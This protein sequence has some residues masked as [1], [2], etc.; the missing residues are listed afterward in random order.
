[1]WD[2]KILF[3]VKKIYPEAFIDV[4]FFQFIARA[5]R[6]PGDKTIL[7]VYMLRAPRHCGDV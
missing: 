1:M 6:Y 4:T 2:G 5:S 7:E 3:S